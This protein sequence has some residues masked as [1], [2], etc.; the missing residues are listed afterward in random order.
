MFQYLIQED[1]GSN[2]QNW[3]SFFHGKYKF[4]FLL[5]SQ[6]WAGFVLITLQKVKKKKKNGQLSFTGDY[7]FSSVAQ[8]HGYHGISF[9]HKPP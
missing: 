2:G 6:K 8:I 7:I 9:C 4:S 1:F 3:I 5:G